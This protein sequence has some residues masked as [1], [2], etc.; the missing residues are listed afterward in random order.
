MTP[1]ANER[2]NNIHFESKKYTECR[3]GSIRDKQV[4]M[5][6]FLITL[7][8][9][10]FEPLSSAQAPAGHSSKNSNNKKIAIARGTMGRGK[11]ASHHPLPAFFSSLSP[12]ALRLKEASAKDRDI[13]PSVKLIS[14]LCDHLRSVILHALFFFFRHL[15]H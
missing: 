9:R 13:L 3:T 14:P 15:P 6:L 2:S 7:A 5:T 4:S 1:P 12:A 10:F 8:S 11:R